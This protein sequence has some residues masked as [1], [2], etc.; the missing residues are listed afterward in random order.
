MS[1]ADKNAILA[2][3]KRRCQALSDADIAALDG[4]FGDALVHIHATGLVQ[5]KREFLEGLA[6]KQPFIRVERGP[7]NI[8][9]LG[10]VA[11]MD[12]P[13]TNTV[14]RADQPEPVTVQAY[15]TQ[16][17]ARE[18]QEW[19]YVAFQATSGPKLPQVTPV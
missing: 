9:V 1:E 12:G 7:L 13:M 15:A 17:L 19:R 14:R 11:I 6:Q 8:R 18:G 4:M 16:V 10:D 5:N 3:E 2:L